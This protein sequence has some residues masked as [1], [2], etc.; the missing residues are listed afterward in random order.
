[1]KRHTMLLLAA[2]ITIGAAA[3]VPEGT[4][5]YYQGADGKTGAE[6]KTALC[7]IIYN[8]TK[9]LTYNEL[10]TAFMTT[11][12]RADGKIWDMYSGVTSYT[13]VTSGSTFSKEGDCYN[14]E[15]SFPK[16][17][18]GGEVFPM[19]TDLHHLYPTDGY[20]NNRRSNYPF[21]ETAGTTYISS[22]G[23]SKLGSCTTEG[24]T[25]T[26]FE[27]NDEYKGDFA[28]T[29][30]YMVTCYEEKLP[31]WYTNN[32]EAQP[33]LDGQTY[34]GLAA[35]QLKMLLRWAA[36]DPVSDKET[37]RNQAVYEIQGNRNPF[38]D[39]P[40]LEEYVWGSMTE[41]TF[42]YDS[43]A[44][45]E[46]YGEDGGE[47]GGSDEE[48]DYAF[49][50]FA[51]DGDGT[52]T[53]P[54]GLMLQ[55][56]G[57]YTTT[58]SLKFD[59]TGDWMELTF[60]EP[61][62]LAKLEFDIKGNSFS[63]G[64]FTLQVSPDGEVY[65]ILDSYTALG[66]KQSLHYDLPEGTQHVKWL[67]TNKSAGNVAMGNIVAYNEYVRSGLTEGNWGT[68]FL[69]YDTDVDNITGATLYSIAGKILD[70]QGNAIAIVLQEEDGELPAAPYLF[71]ATGEQ[72][73]I[74]FTGK[75]SA[76]E[77]EQNGLHGFTTA[78]NVDEEMYLL[79]NNTV[80]CCGERCSIADYRAYIDMDEVP[81]YLGT[82]VGIKAFQV[83]GG[84]IDNIEDI[85]APEL[86]DNAAQRGEDNT[87]YDL[88]GRRVKQPTRRGIYIRGG[89][90][91]VWEN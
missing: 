86:A 34:P 3:A 33:T 10:W 45:P 87:Y 12:V 32:A 9:E 61:A 69:P 81:E 24:Y 75:R 36:Q 22:G 4:G 58:P 66:T 16:S 49:I 41:E 47:G 39:Y 83:G 8:R 46:G 25:G 82:T 71:Q 54:K 53:L 7:G 2:L 11:D 1:M 51:Y 74:G 15:H 59:T 28:R 56:V 68:I 40:G 77:S 29:Y 14:R 44:E 70:R 5:S 90:K 23:H 13:P 79:S 76:L 43:Y 50:P 65:D 55:G 30:F 21:G 38:I 85:T 52:G 63:G 6:L 89:K 48:G 64:T 60:E 88:T 27:P 78:H 19:Y 84:V 18:F 42:S 20:V 31:D 62:L 35:W 67:Y 57:K 37:A 91:V 72:L 17:W 26:V 73:C 80:V